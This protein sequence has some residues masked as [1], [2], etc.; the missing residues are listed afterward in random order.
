M[1]VY[2]PD[3]EYR[4]PLLSFSTTVCSWAPQTRFASLLSINRTCDLRLQRCPNPPHPEVSPPIGSPHCDTCWELIASSFM[5][6]QLSE[7][8]SLMYFS[9]CI[10]VR[11][12]LYLNSSGSPWTL[13]VETMSQAFFCSTHKVYKIPRA[14][15]MFS[16]FFK[17]VVPFMCAPLYKAFY[18][19]GLFGVSARVVLKDTERHM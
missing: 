3:Q 7:P 14:Q 5:S 19:D 1:E 6:P 17:A 10:T 8:S 13:R 9:Y 4:G 18:T 15:W 16:G 11:L 12:F 2:S